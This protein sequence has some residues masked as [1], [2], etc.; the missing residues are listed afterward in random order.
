[1]TKVEQV[2]LV[3]IFHIGLNLLGTL[4]ALGIG[5]VWLFFAGV[6]GAAAGAEHGA[7]AAAGLGGVIAGLG[8]VLACAALLPCLPGLVGGVGLLR[9]RRWARWV[10]VIASAIHILTLFPVSVALGIYSL[11]VLLDAEVAASFEASGLTGDV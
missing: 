8:G 2:R 6:L 7:K 5:V 4:S 11:W 3:G 1:M 9:R 10:V